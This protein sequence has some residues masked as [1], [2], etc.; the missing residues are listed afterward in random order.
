MID[1]LVEPDLA[2]Q[3]G[4]AGIDEARSVAQAVAS[5]ASSQMRRW[6]PACGGLDGG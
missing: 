6:R 3:N 4:R 2:A 5:R 1:S